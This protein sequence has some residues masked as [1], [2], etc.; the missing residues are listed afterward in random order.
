MVRSIA[1]HIIFAARPLLI[2]NWKT[3]KIPSVR[4]LII[5]VNTVAEYEKILAFKDGSITKYIYNWS[6]WESLNSTQR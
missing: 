2:S 6:T 4:E 3:N 1:M 5:K